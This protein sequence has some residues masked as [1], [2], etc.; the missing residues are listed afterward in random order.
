ML[1]ITV[2]AFQGGLKIST[3]IIFFLS[4]I[5]LLILEVPVLDTHIPESDVQHL[6]G[7]ELQKL[8]ESD[9]QQLPESN[10]RHIPKNNSVQKLVVNEIRGLFKE[11]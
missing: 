9:L 10:Q 7:S 6:P 1:K 4:S 11:R 8:Q 5:Y 3:F 2:K